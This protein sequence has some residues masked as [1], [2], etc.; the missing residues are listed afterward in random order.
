[1]TWVSEISSIELSEKGSFDL[2]LRFQDLSFKGFPANLFC[3][4]KKKYV[5]TQLIG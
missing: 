5:Q 4:G 1:M 2:T 3:T